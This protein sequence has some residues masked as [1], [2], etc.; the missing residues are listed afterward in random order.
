[1]TGFQNGGHVT[2]LNHDEKT[3]SCHVSSKISA[4]RVMP[5]TSSGR[6]DILVD[7]TLDNSFNLA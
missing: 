1:M 2:V 4:N 5:A 7:T 6:L 3:E